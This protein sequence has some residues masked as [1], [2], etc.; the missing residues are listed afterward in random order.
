MSVALVILVVSTALQVAA[1][2]IAVRLVWVTGWRWA[3]GLVAAG[4]GLMATRRLY[5]L[6]RFLAALV[7]GNP[8]T[9]FDPL[10]ILGLAISVFL[11]VGLV[12][13]V[14]VF[15]AYSRSEEELRKAREDLERRVR[16]RTAEL[17]AANAG[18]RQERNLLNA[19]MDYLPH[20]IY[21]KDLQSRFLRVNQAMAR[22]FGLQDPRQAIG[23]TDHDFFT[24]EHAMQ[25]LAD[26]Q[27]IVR[28]GHGVIDKE[29][30]ETWPDGRSTWAASTKLPLY[31]DQGQILG[32]FGISQDI[33]AQKRAAE[34]LRAAKEAAEAANRAKSTFL[35][36]MSHEIRT[37]LNAVIGMTELVLKSQLT[38][39]Q[40]EFLSTVHD[41]GE[42]LLS[43]INDILDFSKIEAEKLV[44]ERLKFHLRESL[45]DTMKSF[46]ILAHQR[47]LE[48]ACHI[49]SDVPAWVLGDYHRLRQVV[50]N[51]VNNAIKFTQ[52]GEVVLEVACN[53]GVC[54][55]GGGRALHVV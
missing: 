51:L 9:A 10:E 28:S 52:R 32:S 40:H 23:K 47:G 13:I 50:V 34:A 12:G 35:A 16:D 21:F 4:L 2:A 38:P 43:V 46:A 6:Y 42:A 48:L 20:N 24:D 29:E 49:H 15:R 44:L 8:G 26:E 36:N 14:P 31:D 37:P 1:A 17:A 55:A 53:N 5:L 30:K 19:L 33:T 7:A 45:G 39:Q 3:W 54:R 11:F 27:E 41:S 25:A 22:Y 18:L